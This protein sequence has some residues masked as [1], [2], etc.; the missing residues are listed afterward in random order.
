[1]RAAEHS[2]ER[3]LD[4]L[5]GA[6]EVLAFGVCDKAAVALEIGIVSTGVTAARVKV[7]TVG[8]R[9]PDFDIAVAERLAR[10]RQHSAV[11]VGD[12]AY[13]VP[14]SS[15]QDQQGGVRIE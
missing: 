15:L 5:D 1:M 14:Q 9:L 13:R 11:N 4:R 3:V 8:V 12:F 10:F 2:L 7:G 6:E